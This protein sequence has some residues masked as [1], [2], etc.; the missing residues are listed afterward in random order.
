MWVVYLEYVVGYDVVFFFVEFV[1]FFLGFGQEVYVVFEL[2][3]FD[4]DVGEVLYCVGFVVG[5]LGEGGC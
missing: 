4:F 1:G 3:G 5:V 2:V